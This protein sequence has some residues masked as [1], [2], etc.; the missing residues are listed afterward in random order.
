MPIQNRFDAPILTPQVPQDRA[1]LLADVA[2]MY[3]LEDK[4]QAEIASLI[5]VTRS[6]VSR[7]LKSAREKGIVE[8]RV[9]RK[10]RLDHVLEAA[11]IEAFGLKA[12]RIVAM[13]KTSSRQV[14]NNL[15][16]AGAVL[17]AEYL[18]PGMVLG[19]S[20]GTSVS[21]VV[22]LVEVAEPL[23]VK[24]VQLVGAM[25]AR[26]NDY[27]GNV[28]V[29]RLTDTL[30][31]EGYYL[32]A[33]FLCPNAE[34]AAALRQAQSIRETIDLGKQVTVALLGIGSVDPKYSSYYLAGYVDIEELDRLKRAGAVG[35]VCGLQFDI[36][37]RE[38]CADFCDRTVTILKNDLLNI[39][40]RIGVAGG[41][42]K[43]GPVLGALYGGYVNALVTDRITAR[44]VLKLAGKSL[45]QLT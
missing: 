16:N 38:A 10:L 24:V 36:Q 3:Y 40:L 4:S 29:A 34:T 7:M 2:E 21:A 18:S 27:D 19:L 9:N 17:L 8:V 25:G 12:A 22:N 5:G 32:N 44:E 45:D 13:H 1:S 28:L 41:E 43:A 11:F 14:L 39:P 33:P 26:N 31:G 37:G 6:M 42:G 30:G 23:D 15:G 35:D 20:W